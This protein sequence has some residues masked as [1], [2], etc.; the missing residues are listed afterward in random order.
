MR[1]SMYNEQSVHF[2]TEN[3]TKGIYFASIYK[4]NQVIT[5]KF[6]VE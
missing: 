4:G 5:K 2:D 3:L 6:V 1:M